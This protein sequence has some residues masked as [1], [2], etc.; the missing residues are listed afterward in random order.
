MT[1]PTQKQGTVDNE[2]D[3]AKAI[4]EVLSGL[5]K[6]KQERAVR[7]A[8]ETLNLQAPVV[9]TGAPTPTG[10]APAPGQKAEI[11]SPG[12][13][14]DIRQ[15]AESKAP[16]TDQQF[17]AVV[18]YYYRFEA[19]EDKRKEAIGVKELNDAVRLVGRRRPPAP[20]ATLNNAKNKGYLDKVERGKFQ[21]NSVGENLVAMTLPGK[22]GTTPS[23]RKG[24]NTA[25]KKG[26]LQ[27][28]KRGKARK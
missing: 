10:N 19:P 21:I 26:K 2:L 25:K 24:G 3:A 7:F 22:D 1:Q 6:E 12:P 5:D 9:P 18:A 14:M 17:A 28:K 11:P 20:M 15:F 16:K 13:R 27:A 8:S 23:R 4:V